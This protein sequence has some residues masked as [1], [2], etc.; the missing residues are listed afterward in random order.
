MLNVLAELRCSKPCRDWD[1]KQSSF[2]CKIRECCQDKGLQGCWECGEMEK[3]KKFQF[4]VP[5][6]GETPKKNL[7]KVRKLGLEGGIRLREKCYVWQK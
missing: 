6:H 4:L 2:S 1:E 7:K 3:C 5:F